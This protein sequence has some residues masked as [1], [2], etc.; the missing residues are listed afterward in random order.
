MTITKISG[1]WRAAA[2]DEAYH[3]RFRLTEFGLAD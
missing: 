2:N 1:W 3:P